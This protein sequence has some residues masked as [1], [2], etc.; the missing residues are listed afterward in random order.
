MNAV[1]LSVAALVAMDQHGEVIG[2]TQIP[3]TCCGVDFLAQ[4]GEALDVIIIRPDESSPP[5]CSD[6]LV[7]FPDLAEACSVQTTVNDEHFSGLN[8]TCSEKGCRFA[9]GG[10][11][12]P[13]AEAL[14]SLLQHL[15]PGKNIIR[16]SLL[17]SND[18]VLAR[19]EAILFLWN[20]SDRVVVC[21]I[22]GTITRSNTRG[23]L[24]T[25]VWEKYAYVHDGVC[26][27]LSDLL[28]VDS[29]LRIMYLTSRPLSYAQ[30]TRRFLSE[31]RQGEDQ[32]PDGPLFSHPGTLRSVLYSELVTKDMHEYKSD[33]LLA[34]SGAFV[35]SGG[36][37]FHV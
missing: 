29:S 17:D 22:D 1:I 11:L 5:S 26:E 37:A 19:A 7:Q 31:L 35:C 20:H 2:P 8:M 25:I 15:H 24:D 6:F 33:V 21:D 12:K 30:S 32:L 28:Q 23:V 16:Y 9:Q 3:L 13:P 14:Q 10:S 4:Q 34:S 36:T 27:F 18:T